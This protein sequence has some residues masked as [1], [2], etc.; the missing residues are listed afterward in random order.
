MTRRSGSAGEA[1][2]REGGRSPPSCKRACEI[3]TTDTP[4]SRSVP[5]RRDATPGMPAYGPR[6]VSAQTKHRRPA[7]ARRRGLRRACAPARAAVAG[8]NWPQR[9][10]RPYASAPSIPEPSTLMRHTQ[11]RLVKPATN[12][13]ADTFA[14]WSRCVEGR[15][16]RELPRRMPARARLPYRSCEATGRA[17]AAQ[18]CLVWIWSCRAA[19]DRAA[20]R[21]C[22]DARRK[23]MGAQGTELPTAQ[24]RA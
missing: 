15:S 17:R 21:L 11:S 7:P 10:P 12:G 22:A 23:G 20:C 19:A 16:A 3:M 9:Q 13:F 5:K 2:A 8:S 4:A 6:C 18:V 1:H 14:E 24:R